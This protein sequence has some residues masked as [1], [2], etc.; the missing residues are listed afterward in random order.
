[1]VPY[2]SPNNVYKGDGMFIYKIR[3]QLPS[4]YVSKK[5]VEAV[6]YDLLQRCM[7]IVRDAK[8]KAIQKES[9]I[10]KQRIVTSTVPK[11]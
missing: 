11:N 10:I 7:L 2:L 5:N 3:T 8:I 9:Q 1:M 6:A 4:F